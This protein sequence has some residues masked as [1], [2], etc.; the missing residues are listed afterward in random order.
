MG[1]SWKWENYLSALLRHEILK[2][3]GSLGT[4]TAEIQDLYL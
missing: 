2:V 1:I 3:Y 4:A